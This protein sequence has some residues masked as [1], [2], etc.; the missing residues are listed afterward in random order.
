MC[1]C[2]NKNKLIQI[3]LHN[4]SLTLTTHAREGYSSRSVCLFVC[5]CTADLKGRCIRTVKRGTNMTKIAT[6]KVL[7]SRRVISL[8]FFGRSSW[9]FMSSF[10]LSVN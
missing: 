3:V 8:L 5:L 9:S 10:I 4:S 6:V 2:V 1:A 7:P